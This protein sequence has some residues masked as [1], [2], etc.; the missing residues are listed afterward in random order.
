M[1][2]SVLKI[3]SPR[4]HFAAAAASDHQFPA[5]LRVSPVVAASR[6]RVL[7]GR[8]APALLPAASKK[9]AVASGDGEQ[10][11][12]SNVL[13]LESIRSSLIKQEDTIIFGLLERSQFCYNPDT[14]DPN[15]SGIVGFNG[16]LVEFMV[17]ETEKVH[18]MM[19]RYKSPD[20][21]PFFVVPEPVLPPLQYKNVLH[22]AAASINVN[23][24][25]WTVYFDMLLPRLVREGSDG[26]CGSSAF[27]D[28][29]ILQDEDKLMETLTYVKVED[30]VKNRVKNKAM[31]FGQVV[32]LDASPANDTPLK[33]EPELAAELYCRWVMPLTKRV[34]VQYLLRRLD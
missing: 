14:Y 22:P 18:A 9:A 19:G 8:A 3:P 4:A 30:N 20:E 26:N 29:I 16:S 12:G 13:S 25:I 24:T 15:A 7:A 33:I 21:H 27:C 11:D 28:T 10:S 32:N 23:R 5:S 34:Q 2:L 6:A 31:T 1:E 17:Q